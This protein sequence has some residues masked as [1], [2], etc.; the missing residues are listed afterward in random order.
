MFFWDDR[1]K[2][3]PNHQEF[4]RAYKRYLPAVLRHNCDGW[5]IEY[6]F[7]NPVADKLD[8]KRILVNL[9]RK[10]YRTLCEFKMAVNNM[11]CTIN[12]RLAGG[13]S[14]FGEIS[15]V[16]EYATIEEVTT[17]F[18]KEK[19]QELRKNSLRSYE[20]FCNI[21]SSWVART[22]PNCRCI[23]FNQTHAVRFMDELREK[24][25]RTRSYNN[26]LKL[27]RA[28]F[29]WA[30]EHC[31]CKQNPFEK[32]KPKRTEAKIRTIILPEHRELIREYL[33]QNNPQYLIICELVYSALI[34]PAEIARIRVEQL[35]L[36]EHYIYLP[37]TQ[38]K[39]GH[40]RNAPLSDELMRL[41][42]EHT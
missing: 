4:S 8:R 42:A 2:K 39:N 27:A 23:L 6:Y 41:L 1:R 13:W 34:R 22:I 11:I 28:L 40:H 10:R 30:V 32:L 7:Y 33:L 14:P 9:L 38:T 29:S 17:A 5:Y 26:N 21:F 20:S 25:L 3:L 19:R 31:Y 18:I 12:A 36:K 16:R 24:H 15:N 37:E 35:H